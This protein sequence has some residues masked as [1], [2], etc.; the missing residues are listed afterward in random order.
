MQAWKVA[1]NKAGGVAIV[2]LDIPDDAQKVEFQSPTTQARYGRC[3]FADV[4]SIKTRNRKHELVDI[5]EA[6]SAF[7]FNFIYKPGLR[8]YPDLFDDCPRFEC[9]AG[10]HYFLDYGAAIAYSNVPWFLIR[11]KDF[12]RMPCTLDSIFLP[13]L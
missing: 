2:E 7:N 12:N 5:D 6:Y 4:V 11:K 1:L 8:V 13:N 9:L 10:I 3:S